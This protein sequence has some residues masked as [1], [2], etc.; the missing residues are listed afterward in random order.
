MSD[1]A[2][3]RILHKWLMAVILNQAPASKT[4][5]VIC[6]FIEKYKIN[7]L[8]YFEFPIQKVSKE[9]RIDDSSLLRTIGRLANSK[10]KFL[11]K[12]K[13]GQKIFIS[14]NWSHLDQLNFNSSDATKI[15]QT[16][17]LSENRIDQEQTGDFLPRGNGGLND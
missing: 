10:F 6:E 13:K 16:K 1:K 3:K 4:A 12:E 7:I 15:A 9:W 17:T 11:S 5:L 14:L 2:K 8:N